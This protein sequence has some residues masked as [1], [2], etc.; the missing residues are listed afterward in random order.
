MK[1]MKVDSLKL[2]ERNTT[3]SRIYM[4]NFYIFTRKKNE[5]QNFFF[6][7]LFIFARALADASYKK[8]NN[9][10]RCLDYNLNVY[11]PTNFPIF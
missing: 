4:T 10:W 11:N 3:W 8:D 6:P 1:G 7:I 9:S 5:F 2:S